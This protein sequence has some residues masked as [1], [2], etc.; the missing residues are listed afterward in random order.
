ME[1][2]VKWFSKDRG[3]GFITD[4]DD[5]DHHF[6]VRD[7]V[8]DTL[9]ST[10][11]T[12]SFGPKEALRGPRATRVSIVERKSE[13]NNNGRALCQNCGKAIIP[14]II[15][16][17]G[18]PERSICPFCGCTHKDFQEESSM[19]PIG[20]MFLLL[21]FAGF[22]SSAPKLFGFIFGLYLIWKICMYIY[23]C[24]SSAKHSDAQIVFP[25]KK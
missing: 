24:S 25:S 16:H 18:I 4:E 2:R 11:D 7:V 20:L 14:R 5:K 8:G 22:A 15:T 12:V 23:R 3:Y 13:S 1:G 9:P 17:K 19:G 21:L 10:G 6:A